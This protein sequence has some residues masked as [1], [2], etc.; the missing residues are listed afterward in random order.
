MPKISTD[1]IRHLVEER[2]ASGIWPPGCAISEAE[3]VQEFGVSRTPV[4]EALLQL[5]ALGFVRIV[6]RAGIFVAKL[7]VKELLAMLETLAHLEGLCA[8]L[9][10]TRIAAA[11]QL[12][13]Q[14]LQAEAGRAVET[15]DAGRYA[16]LNQD[17]HQLLYRSCL[18]PFLVEQITLIRN[19]TAAY[20]LKRFEDPNGLRRSWDS[21]ARIVAAVLAGDENA[22]SE[23]ALEHIAMGGREFAELVSRL[24]EDLFSHS[25][26]PRSGSLP[27]SPFWP[28]VQVRATGS[29]SDT[30]SSTSPRLLKTTQG[31]M[32]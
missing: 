11:D 29:A 15:A 31:N 27:P 4:R 10:A 6:P 18:N 17:F 14:R 30:D 8:R 26:R 13:L 5:S 9:S 23:A 32:P 25:T 2:I 28:F 16:A 24:P 3:L 20:R 19:R 22:A 1:R 12:Q 21:H 7:S